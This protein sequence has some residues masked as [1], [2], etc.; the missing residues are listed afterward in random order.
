MYIFNFNFQMRFF[1]TFAIHAALFG[2]RINFY[3]LNCIVTKMQVQGKAANR[4]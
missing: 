3:R 1:T 4:N 2:W